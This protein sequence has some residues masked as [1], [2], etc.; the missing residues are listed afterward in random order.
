MGFTFSDQAGRLL[1]PRGCV[2]LVSASHR[3]LHKRPEMRKQV[4]CVSVNIWV[5]KIR[6][7]ASGEEVVILTYL[8]LASPPLSLA[9]CQEKPST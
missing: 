9:S 7:S 8:Q 6:E 2:L 4:V 5:K 3:V 1:G